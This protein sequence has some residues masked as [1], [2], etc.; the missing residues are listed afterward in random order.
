D[1][2]IEFSAPI[3]WIE[4][5]LSDQQRAQIFRDT[6]QI[7]SPSAPG[8][9]A[10]GIMEDEYEKLHWD[11]VALTGREP[12]RGLSLSQLKDLVNHYRLEAARKEAQRRRKQEYRENFSESVMQDPFLAAAITELGLSPSEVYSNPVLREQVW[13]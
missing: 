5:A 7:V 13:E 12:P 9:V 11:Y 1:Q 2:G 8:W 6:G 3:S 4:S 10:S